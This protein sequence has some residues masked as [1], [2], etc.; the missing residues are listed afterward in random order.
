MKEAPTTSMAFPNVCIG[1]LLHPS[2]DANSRL[3]KPG[4]CAENNNNNNHVVEE[5][6]AE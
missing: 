4:M 3:N 2:S 5:E 6:K 1:P